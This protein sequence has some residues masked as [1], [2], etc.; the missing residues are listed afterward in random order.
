MFENM[1]ARE[2]KLAIAVLCLVP[3][4]LLFM[5]IF[6]VI[7]KY[8]ENSQEWMRLKSD[9]SV[10]EERRT[11]ANKA[12]R[13][14]NYYNSISFSPSF[15]DAGNDYSSWLKTQ[16]KET[17]LKY[18]TITPRDVGDFKQN[19]QVIGRKKRFS[20]TATGR[21][22]QLTDFLT[23]FYS[24]DALHRINS[25]KVNASAHDKSSGRGGK[26]IRGDQLSITFV[27]EIAALTTADDNPDFAKNFREMARDKAEY[28]AVILR[29]N[30][31]GPANNT[32]TVS[33]RPSRSYT[34]MKEARVEVK[35]QDADDKDKLT[36]EL[37][38]SDVKGAKL[39]ASG[40]LSARLTVPGQK[41]GKYSFKV[42]VID[43]GL[44][45]M[46]NFTVV[47]LEFKDKVVKKPVKPK[48]PPPFVHAT[49]TRITGTTQLPNDDWQVWIQVRTTGERHKLLVGDSFELDNRDWVVESIEPRSAVFSVD[50]KQRKFNFGVTFDKPLGDEE[51]VTR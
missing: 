14:R 36:F 43:S 45:P 5:S 27:I 3:V 26:K 29:R 39:V 42:K 47:T 21:L 12:E 11:S 28:E 50:G 38:E 24:I 30:I 37:V 19:G 44:P 33:A 16:L 51:E 9:I 17:K 34:S 32:P 7:G 2:R 35:G 25:I 18:K 8:G 4:A 10:E 1:T 15:E 6:W 20:F 46:E 23:R 40:R 49:E 41:A 13:R 31:F 22:D 48:E